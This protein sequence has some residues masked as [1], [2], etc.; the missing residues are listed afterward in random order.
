MSNEGMSIAIGNIFGDMMPEKTKKKNCKVK[1][2]R[3]ILREQEAQKLLDM[4][5][6][7]D[8]AIENAEQNGIIFIDEIDKIASGSR[9]T[10]GA[11]VSRE[12]VQR[13]ILPIVEGSVINTKYGPVKTDHIL[14]IGAGAF[15]TAKPTDLIPELQG[16]FPIRVTL[17]SLSKEDFKEILTKP[18]NALIKQHKALLET[19][20]IEVEFTEDAIDQIATMSFLMN[21]QT[22]N[23]G[24]RR[25]HTVLEKLLEDISFNIPEMDTEKVVIDEEYVKEKF[26]ETIHAEDLDRYIL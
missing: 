14:F 18:E 19:E 4:D 15:H 20:G 5:Q 12:G 22:E 6:V 24:A 8:E 3:K 9:M 25:L 26:Q 2:A 16:R 23:I 1:E 10:S 21:E 11:D 17:E 13:D 7:S